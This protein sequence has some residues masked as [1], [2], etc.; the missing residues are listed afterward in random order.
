MVSSGLTHPHRVEY[1]VISARK[2]IASQV[3]SVREAISLT[4]TALVLGVLAVTVDRRV[5]V[6]GAGVVPAPMP[7]FA[8]HRHVLC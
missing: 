2:E 1:E 5:V 6:H 7:A 3:S 4:A 8:V